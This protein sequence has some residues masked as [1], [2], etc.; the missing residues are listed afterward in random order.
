[1]EES[2]KAGPNKDKKEEGSSPKHSPEPSAAA[3]GGGG[4]GT[5]PIELSNVPKNHE[6]NAFKKLFFKLGEKLSTTKQTP[7]PNEYITTVSEI[8]VYRVKC[9][10]VCNCLM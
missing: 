7:F 9:L 8:D 10:I 6:V 5:K 3:N 1:M 4:T 2:T